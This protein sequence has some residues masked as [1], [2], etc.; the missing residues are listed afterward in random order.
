MT[1]QDNL[2]DRLK[3]RRTS[4]EVLFNTPEEDA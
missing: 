4:S 2:R 1:D 3:N